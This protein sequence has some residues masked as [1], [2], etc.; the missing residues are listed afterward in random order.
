[1]RSRPHARR[2]VSLPGRH[3]RHARVEEPVCLHR[4][5]QVRLVINPAHR[6]RRRIPARELIRPAPRRR[7]H[8]LLLVAPA[9]R[10]DTL[11]VFILPR[12]NAGNKWSTVR[13]DDGVV[14]PAYGPKYLR[15]YAD[16][17]W[18]DNLL[19]LPRK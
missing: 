8:A 17:R 5:V 1:L 6:L 12:T 11:T 19:A 13:V 16:G 3:D 2:R 14:T 10:L 4:P 7:R 18:T 15:T 9:V